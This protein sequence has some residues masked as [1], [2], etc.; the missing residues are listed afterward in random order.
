MVQ[1][2]EKAVWDVDFPSDFNQCQVF[3]SCSADK[4]VR[5]PPVTDQTRRDIPWPC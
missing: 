3:A 1:G 5:G 4:T 2:H